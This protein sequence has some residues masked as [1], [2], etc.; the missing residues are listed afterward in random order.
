MPANAFKDLLPGTIDVLAGITQRAKRELSVGSV[1]TMVCVAEV[2]LDRPLRLHEL[3]D[4]DAFNFAHDVLGILR[5]WDH[6]ARVMRDCFVP[7]YTA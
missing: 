7:R 2:H 5:H 1:E 3:L 4:A 6:E